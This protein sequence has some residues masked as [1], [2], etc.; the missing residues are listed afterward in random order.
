MIVGDFVK[1]K[2]DN[3]YAITDDRMTKGVVIEV[4]PD[5]EIDVK[6]LEHEEEGH[7]GEVYCVHED[8]FD[9]IGHQK[10]FNRAEVLEL[11]QNGCK[12]AV[13]DYN[14]SGA[15]LRRANLSGAN[16][17]CANLSG[18][19][20]SD[21]NL[22]GANLSCANLS[23]ANLSGANLS[24]ANLSGA[25]LSGADLRRANLSGANL[26]CA[27]LSGANLSGADLRR[28][29]LSGADLSDANLRRADLSG[30]DLSGADLS[31]ANLSGANL[32]GADLRRADL[33]GADLRRADLDFSCL[34]LRCDG[35]RWKIDKRIACQFAYHLCSM[36]C[37]DKE[38]I[39]MR[40]SIL[41]FANQFHRVD[42]CGWLEEIDVKEAEQCI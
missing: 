23:G 29:N 4:H 24:D 18:A 9:V 41:N 35:L 16:L 20:L 5:G 2:P 37:D 13:L 15:D 34:P 1:G 26:S 12:K 31:G 17:S 28:A 36:E 11:L 8:E 39:E 42:E 19:N 30:A 7:I 6:V 32:S 14:L 40:N 38:F 27:N 21:A 10:E 33:S 3:G 25:N 22:S